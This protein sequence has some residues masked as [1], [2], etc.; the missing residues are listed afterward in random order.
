MDIKNGRLRDKFEK[1]LNSRNSVV[2]GSGSLIQT[3]FKSSI[4][5]SGR[6][7]QNLNFYSNQNSNHLSN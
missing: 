2:E 3:R 7:I 1:I 6:R 5:S 4:V